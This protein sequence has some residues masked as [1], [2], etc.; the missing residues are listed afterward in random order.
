MSNFSS[1]SPSFDTLRSGIESA[2]TV[3]EVLALY[4]DPQ[5]NPKWKQ[6]QVT[7]GHY[8]DRHALHLARNT[9]DLERPL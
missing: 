5:T 8:S 1:A 4:K 6:S 7:M 2:V 3:R 9:K